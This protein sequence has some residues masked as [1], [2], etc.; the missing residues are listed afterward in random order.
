MTLPDGRREAVQPFDLRGA[1]LDAV[2]GDVFLNAS[3]PLGAGDWGYVV[4]LCEQPG[5]RLRTLS[6][7]LSSPNCSLRVIRVSADRA[8]EKHKFLPP[9]A[10]SGSGRS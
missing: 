9:H 8:G 4:A 2:G 5:L 1:Q 3:D 6:E 7:S 10:G